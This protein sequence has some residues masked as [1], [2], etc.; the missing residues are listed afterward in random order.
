MGCF[1][2][3]GSSLE[4][5]FYLLSLWQAYQA[6]Q[7]A[8]LLRRE[9][10]SLKQEPLTSRKL[11]LAEQAAFYLA[12]PPAVLVHEISHAIPIYVW[13]GRV[14]N[15]GYGFYWGY[16]QPDRF[17]PAGQEWFIALAGTLGSL[18]VGLLYWLWAMRQQNRTLQFFGLRAFRFQIYFSLLIYP[19]FTA[20]TFIGDWRTIYDF[21]TT[22]LLSGATAVVHLGLLGWYFWADRSGRFE[23]VAHDSV[24][25]QQ[26]FAQLEAQAQMN[27]QDAKIQLQ[28]IE[29]LRRGRAA[30]RAKR[31]L[32]QFLQRNTSSGEA[33]L[34]QALLALENKR[35]V[36]KTAV[37]HIQRALEL[38]LPETQQQTV[39][40]H[41]LGQYY[42]ERE[43][44][45]EAAQAFSQV[46]ALSQPADNPV[47]LAEAYRGRSVAYRRQKQYDLAYQDV[48]Q[49]ISLAQSRGQEEQV[50]SLRNELQIIEQHAGR[51]LGTSPSKQEGGEN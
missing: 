10:G 30:N 32:Q 17:F 16:V 21:A 8:G 49:A 15:C 25:A 34:L 40:H 31:Q 12:V 28:Y 18:A 27:P 5:I 33:Y 11:H 35:T 19:I 36:T 3:Q 48:Q 45:T 29:A 6:V 14:V 7:L 38:G 9:W 44:Y 13:G 24:A 22:P 20:V 50:K 2:F 23:M 42:L 46:I 41:L 1:N 47:R 26:Q 43:A 39:A 4:Y 37:T 51:P